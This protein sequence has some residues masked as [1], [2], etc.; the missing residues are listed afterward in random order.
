MNN[1]V[2]IAI[3]GAG[4]VGTPLANVL[5]RQGWSVAL[6]DAAGPREKNNTS[7]DIQASRA[8]MQRCTALSMGT[9][10]WFE[11]QELWAEVA[12][13]A[14]PIKQVHVSHKGYFGS[15]RLQA[16]ELNVD[17]VGYVVSNETLNRVFLKQLAD[18][19]VQHMTGAKV[20]AVEY[21]DNVVNIQYA[22]NTLSARLLIAADG[23]SSVVRQCAGIDTRQV[24]YD[25]CAFLG[26][27]QLQHQHGN[28]AYERFTDCGP[29]AL[30][31][32]PGPY[33]SFVDCVDSDDREQIAS[34]SDMDYLKRLQTR[35][36][37]RLG[38]FKAVGPRFVTPLVRIE[39]TEQVAQRTVLLGNAAR[40]LHPV[41]G[42]GYNLAM[43][44]AAHLSRVLQQYCDADPGNADVLTQFVH[45]R[46]DDQGQVVQFTD[47]LARGFRGKAALPAHV[48]A[49][50]LVTLDTFTPLR[51]RF[52][53]RTMG[54]S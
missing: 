11:S 35:F 43:R 49:L 40:L 47:L 21:T 44:D 34:M 36:G 12:D 16:D 39:A 2:D 50:G 7:P 37:Y 13:D 18:S 24:D 38:R 53:R 41:G 48:R 54:L 28:I 29:L 19:S 1:S 15:T 20:S 5:S 45:A 27:V 33:M 31:P 17:A 26:T 6:I 22:D 52:A 46:Q 30:L 51:Q 42:Q 32:R 4:L 25:Q 23:V 8:L 14:C 9:R 3:V 10:Q